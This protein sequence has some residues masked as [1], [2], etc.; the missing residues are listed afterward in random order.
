MKMTSEYLDKIFV[1]EFRD[2]IRNI[3]TQ[4]TFSINKI[5]LPS[6]A[7]TVNPGIKL[8]IDGIVDPIYSSLN[9]TYVTKQE[10]KTITRNIY[11]N[12]GEI[13]DKED[14]H[15]G[16]D[17]M[18]VRTENSINL[19]YKYQPSDK[20]LEYIDYRDINLDTYDTIPP[21]RFFYYAIPTKY[22][23]R[24]TNTALVLSDKKKPNHYGGVRLMT[25][26][27]YYIYLYIVNVKGL[28]DIETQRIIDTD[29]NPARLKQLMSEVVQYLQTSEQVF[30]APEL[31]VSV[32]IDNSGSTNLAI[33]LYEATQDYEERTDLTIAEENVSAKDLLGD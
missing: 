14:F 16:A 19:P 9:K 5:L 22:L 27:G 18:I 24:V 32:P 20:E 33:T 23:Y 3:R 28:K 26:W 4:T 1:R 31:E 8:F 30:N 13:K 21:T 6:V 29:V 25:T 10:Q 2:M 17:R 7:N 15:A 11:W 12:S